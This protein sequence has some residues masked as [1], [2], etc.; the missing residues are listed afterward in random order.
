M[1]IPTPSSTA[2]PRSLLSRHKSTNARSERPGQPTLDASRALTRSDSQNTALGEANGETPSRR[3]FL[4]Q[5][6]LPRAVPRAKGVTEAEPAQDA[7]GS[8]ATANGVTAQQANAG[9]AKQTRPRPR[10]LYQTRASQQD[11]VVSHSSRPTDA[12]RLPVSTGLSRTQSLKRP[13]VASQAMPPPSRP[14][15]SRTQSTSTPIGARKETGEAD[16]PAPRVERPKSLAMVSGHTRSLSNAPTET[17]PGISRASARQDGLTRSA[18]TRAKLGQPHGRATASTSRQPEDP[19]Q[20]KE[21]REALNQEP[22]KL[23]RPAFSTLQQHFTPRKTGKAPTSTFIHAPE[24]V[25][26]VLPPEIVAL[27]SELL[28]LHLLHAPSALSMRQ[29]EVSAQKALRSKFDEVASLNQIMQEKER[30]GQEQKNVLALREWNGSNAI[31]GLAAHIQAL[32]A[33]LHELPSLLDPG[34][35]FFYLV[36]AFSKWLSRAD[37]VWSDRDGSGGHGSA[38]QSLAG[39]G[40]TWKEEHAAMMRKLTAFSRHL[41]GLPPTVPGSSIAYIVTRCQA[42]IEGLLS[43]LQVMQ[44]TEADAVSREEHWVEQRLRTI[45]QDVDVDSE[46]DEEAWRLY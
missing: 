41:D 26:H 38:M 27:Q 7:T 2:K 4:P 31:S 19:V 16:N 42:L 29:W 15:H 37:Q 30:F 20:A 23:V 14:L 36:E 32:S 9:D 46:T 10:S 22:R 6:G 3:S 24:P 17:A 40:D 1:P 13:S 11:T 45:A 43:E 44:A 33:P 35:R 25:N 8:N 34:G 12:N 5:R 18:S 39:L 21:P 28:Q